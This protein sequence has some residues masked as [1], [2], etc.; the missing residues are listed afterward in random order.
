[1]SSS[2][3]DYPLRRYGNDHDRYDWSYSALRPKDGPGK[4]DVFIVVPLEFFPLTP[5]GKPFKHPG[6]M[7]T[8]YPDLRHFSTRDYGNRVGVFR[9]LDA[10]K[11]AGMRAVFPVNGMLLD[12]C[13]PLIERIAEAGHEIA[14]HGVSTD[15][16]HYDGLS[17]AD[18]AGYI[19]Q[20]LELFAKKG[21]Q[22]KT[23]MSPARNESY[24]TP[25]LLTKFGFETCLD[26]EM[27]QVPVAMNTENGPLTCLPNHFELNDFN[28][29][30]TKR[31]SEDEWSDQLVESAKYLADEAEAYG[32]RVMGFTLTPYIAGLPFRIHALRKTL[33][34]IEKLNK[35]RVSTPSLIRSDWLQK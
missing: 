20:T 29:L 31:Q 21:L 1:M 28:L 11:A 10:L 26:W 15:H 22:P 33:A 25:D 30:F 6:A 9:I 5:S 8:P 34:A 19:E 23:W 35:V 13:Q 12:R 18:E 3:P 4:L 27:D 17:E 2:Y 32:P 24:R 16:I 7:V 14:A